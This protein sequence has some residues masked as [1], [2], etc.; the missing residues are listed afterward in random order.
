MKKRGRMQEKG[1]KPS[2]SS[3]SLILGERERNKGGKKHS[4]LLWSLKM[5]QQR[6]WGVFEPSEKV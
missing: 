4:R 6:H 3:A 5:I 2:D 1:W